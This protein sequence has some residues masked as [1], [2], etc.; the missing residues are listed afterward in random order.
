MKRLEDLVMRN[1]WIVAYKIEDVKE[2]PIQKIVMGERIVLFR[3]EDS[4]YGR[5]IDCL[6]DF[7]VQL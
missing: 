6:W 1:D 4:C 5:K 3:N 7:I 2:D